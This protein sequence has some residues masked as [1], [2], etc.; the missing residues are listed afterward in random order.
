MRASILGATVPRCLALKADGHLC[1]RGRHVPVPPQGTSGTG[2]V[3]LP[4]PPL[5]FPSHVT[6]PQ[7]P[8]QLHLSPSIS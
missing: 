7:C 3:A 8:N 1:G 2:F 5:P 6:W 4:A